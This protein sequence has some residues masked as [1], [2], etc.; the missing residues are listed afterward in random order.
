MEFPD[1]NIIPSCLVEVSHFTLDLYHTLYSL[2]TG[3]VVYTYTPYI[4]IGLIK[5]LCKENILNILNVEV[6]S[7]T[8]FNLLQ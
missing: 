7:R 8:K 2:Y 6:L 4:Y 1:T 5:C 3:L